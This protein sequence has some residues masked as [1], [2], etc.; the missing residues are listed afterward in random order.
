[1]PKR[2]PE[3]KYER[4]PDILTALM[5]IDDDLRLV[6]PSEELLEDLELVI[7]SISAYIDRNEIS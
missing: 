3:P 6:G 2:K 7:L 4:L 1:M 5:G